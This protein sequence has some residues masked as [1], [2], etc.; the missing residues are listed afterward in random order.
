VPR[1]YIVL[2]LVIGCTPCEQVASPVQPSPPAVASLA[3][4]APLAPSPATSVGAVGS[5]ADP[6][7]EGSFAGVGAANRTFGTR[8]YPKLVEGGTGNFAFS[9]VSVQLALAMAWAGA[10]GDTAREI[11]EVSAFQGLEPEVHAAFAKEVRRWNGG[12]ATGPELRVANAAFM[13]GGFKAYQEYRDLLSSS[14]GAAI[15][16]VA[17]S[18]EAFR[19]RVNRWVEQATRGKIRR[20]MPPPEP[21]EIPSSLVLANAV[22]FHGN[23]QEPFNRRFTIP[24]RFELESGVTVAVPMMTRTGVRRWARRPDVELVDL[25]YQGGETSMVIALPPP[26]QRLASL[27]GQLSTALLENWWTSFRTGP[28]GLVVPRFTLDPPGSIRLDAALKAL[29]MRA[30]FDPGRADFRRIADFREPFWLAA[31][32]HKAM[33]QVDEEGTTA[34]AATAL[35]A[36]AIVEVPTMIVN[37]PFLFF[38]V[39]WP[40][41]AI[42]F[43][44]RVMDPRS[45]G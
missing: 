31:A 4:P 38:I 40:S 45:K 29:G 5:T 34:A 37:R 10:R 21:G 33:V 27:E 20:L 36:V 3:A 26:G 41:G 19:K 6:A 39:D 23:W 13:S 11:A 44:G 24:G 17:G 12:M 32:Y 42:L 30:A 14:Y 16:Q 15:E 35:R 7:R 43:M 18:E 22:Y 25:A 9:P 28:V 8:L 1:Y 2:L